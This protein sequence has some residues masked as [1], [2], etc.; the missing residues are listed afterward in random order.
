[1]PQAWLSKRNQVVVRF[2]ETLTNN[3]VNTESSNT[4]KLYKSAMAVDLIYGSRHGK[5][6]SEMNL[7]ARQLSNILSHDHL[8]DRNLSRRGE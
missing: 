5:Y 1:M 8:Q 6:V 3:D 7:T 2:I 4:E